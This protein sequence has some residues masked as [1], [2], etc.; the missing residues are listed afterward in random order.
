MELTRLLRLDRLDA[1][2]RAPIALRICWQGHK[3]RPSTGEKVKPADWDEAKAKVRARAR[4]ASDIN[5]RLDIYETHLRTF[6]YRQENAGQ[7]VSEAMARAEVERIR[8]EELGRG[9][10]KVPTTPEPAGQSLADFLTT[11]ETLLPGGLTISTA[12]QIR[13][14]RLHL[15]AFWPGL[16]WADLKVN[17]L[18]QLKNYFSE[19]VGLSDNTV[20]AYFGS[21]RG[22]MKYAT[23]T[24]YPVPA[25]YALVSGSPAEVI[26]PALSRDHLAIINQLD[27]DE[28]PRLKPT[29]W[30]FQMACYTGLRYSDL[31]QI[32]RASVSLVDGYPCLMALQ[33]K[34]TG[35]VAIPLVAPAI[36]LLDQHPDGQ[37]VPALK[38]YNENLKLIGKLANLTDSVTVSSRYKGKLLHSI[39]PLSDTLS[40]HTARRTFASMMTQG[41]LNT[42]V[43]QQLMGHASIAS[44]EK[45]IRLPSQVVLRQTLDAWK[46]Q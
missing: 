41:G 45:Y 39:L 26:R 28:M 12:R 8:N 21:F 31:S 4:F 20:S 7:L 9:P 11:Y 33:Q 14:I 5:A 42:R 29:A 16:N 2:G 19:E 3:I 23:A 35:V 44:T 15:D 18:N 13:A 22:A 25:D 30:L 43:L 24:G 17:A 32:R 34:T 27:L 1:S 6:F 36:E 38:T 10:K 37:V 40:S 46:N